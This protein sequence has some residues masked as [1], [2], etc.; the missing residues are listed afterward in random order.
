MRVFVTGASS[1][2]VVLHLEALP[3]A[4]GTSFA[5]DS[6]EA[7]G[8]TGAGKALN[9]ARLGHDVHLHTLLADDPPG[10]RIRTEVEAGGV[11]VHA[12]P[13]AHGTEQH[14]N[15]MSPDGSRASIFRNIAVPDGDL[16]VEALLEL[17]SESDATI[18]NITDYVRALIPGTTARGI[19]F[20]T[21]LHDWDGH[22]PYH[23]DFLA[24]R[25]IVLSDARLGDRVEE[26]CRGLADEGRLVVCTHGAGGATAWYRSERIHA[27]ARTVS[28]VVDTNGAG[29]A[30]TAGL[31]HGLAEGWPL[32]R[33]LDAANVAGATSVAS[34]SLASDDLSAELLETETATR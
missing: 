5:A 23:R 8:S 7:T 22:D 29:D 10:S 34:R 19:P 14:V 6:Y 32:R 9:L 30:F 26:L 28:A 31:V 3:T 11:R 18:L 20:W 13:A 1:W 12:D 16:D 33:A 2:D 25:Q 15:L 21:D 4:P 17:A 27:P 24:A